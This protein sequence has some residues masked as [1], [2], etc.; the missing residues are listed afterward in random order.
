M[1]L[2]LYRQNLIEDEGTWF[3]LETDAGRFDLT[4]AF[5]AGEI[6]VAHWLAQSDPVAFLEEYAKRVTNPL[7][8]DITLLA[9]ID[10]QEV[11][12]AGVTY[13]RSKVARM[14][15]SEDGGDFYDKVYGAARPELFF[16][17]LPRRVVGPDQ[18][19]RIRRDSTWNVPE[20]EMTLVVSSAGQFVGVTVGN[21]V[22]SRSIEGENPLYLPQ[23]KCYD[24]ACALGP[25]IRIV[26]GAFD[27]RDLAIRLEITRG[28]ATVFADETTTARMK[29]TPEELVEYLYR[30]NSFPDGAF[31]MTGTGLVPPDTF[32]LQ[33]GDAVSITIEGVGT[34]TNPVA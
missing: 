27:L 7:I 31:L 10:E 23:A 18:P 15:E 26:D 20:P 21:D 4:E 12:A 30:E 11:W 29:R 17:A 13:E 28:G 1:K 3:G 5:W 32:T 16:K 25:A 6:S 22:S 2:F 24:G 33:S 9:P 14:E 34:L 8:D 19:I